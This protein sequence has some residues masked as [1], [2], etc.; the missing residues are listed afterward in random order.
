M[1][2]PQESEQQM[3]RKLRGADAKAGVEA[4]P[5][6][7]MLAVAIQHHE[8]GRLDEAASLYRKILAADPRRAAANYLLGLVACQQGRNAVAV[9]LISKAIALTPAVPAFHSNL[10]VALNGMGREHKALA[11]FDTAVRLKPDYVDAHSNRGN[12]LN[13]MGRFEEALAA[14]DTALRL[15]PDFA[16]AHSNRGNALYGMGRFEESLAAY[17]AAL[18]F[19]PDFADA[20]SNRGNALQG[21]GR[22]EESLE[23]Y[24]TALHFNPD[25]ADALYNRSLLK[26]RLRDFDEGFSDYKY[27][28]KTKVFP[29]KRPNTSVPSASRSGLRGRLLLWGEQG[30][31]D[32]IFY[33]GLLSALP[34]KDVCVTLSANHRLHPIYNRS[35][36]GVALL[37][38]SALSGAS[39]DSGFDA[40]APIGDLGHLLDLNAASIQTTRSPYLRSDPVKRDGYRK[41]LSTFGS[42]LICG[43]A[44]QSANK[45]LGA[46]KSVDLASLAPLLSLPGVDFVNLQYGDVDGQIADLKSKSG[47]DIHQVP[48]L[49]LFQDIDGLLALIDACDVIVTTSNVTAHL[50]GAIGKSAA[51]LVPNSNG[52]FWYWHENDEFSFWYPSLR[53]FYQNNALTWDQTIKECAD[54]IKRLL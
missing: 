24:N 30:L 21:L 7:A 17:N 44:W 43:I 36:P 53:L 22:F 20:H 6:G 54:W 38:S 51:V 5:A 8:S 45:K 47:I 39:I 48:D 28:W 1:P 2:R 12:A 10:G 3:D 15:K 16:E 11:A 26:L 29:G 31:G 49:D 19:R 32:E 50:A 18:R 23:A 41:T 14:C 34:E 13:G 37:D 27:R 25:F 9:D 52:R 40:Q 35:F 42:G 4:D 33:A 46:A